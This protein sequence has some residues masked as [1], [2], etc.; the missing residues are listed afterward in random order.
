MTDP[1]GLA[2]TK[3]FTRDNADRIIKSV[4]PEGFV[5]RSYFNK[6]NQLR[7]ELKPVTKGYSCLVERKYSPAGKLVEMRVHRLPVA[8][9]QINDETTLEML[10]KQYPGTPQ[11][12]IKRYFHEEGGRKRTTCKLVFD[13]VKGV[14]QAAISVKLFDAAGRETCKHQSATHLMINSLADLTRAPSIS[15]LLEIE[16]DIA[17]IMQRQCA[18]F[19]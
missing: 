12:K 6:L 18:V 8:I 5:T 16:F 19:R 10:K 11:D 13:E 1:S 9:D 2:L 4:D 15:S 14:Y 17:L 3:Q 7:F